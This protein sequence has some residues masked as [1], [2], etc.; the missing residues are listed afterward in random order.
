MTIISE[1]AM[2]VSS[3]TRASLGMKRIVLLSATFM[4]PIFGKGE[5]FN[6]WAHWRGHG[7]NS[8]SMTAQPPIEWSRSKN[9]KWKAEIPGRGSGSPVIWGNQV[10]VVSAVSE[11]D[12]AALSSG[13]GGS[14]NGKKGG[15]PKKFSFQLFCFDRETG[16]SIWSRTA[17]EAAPHEG[18]H[19]TNGYASASPCSDG[20]RV[21]AHFGSRGLF[22]YNMDGALLWSRTDLGKMTVRAGFGEGSSPT[23][24]GDKILVPW[25]HEGPSALYALD[26]RTGETIWKADRD[27]PTCWATPLVVPLGDSFQVIMNGQTKAR[28]YDLET[29]KELWSCGG[30]TERPVASAVFSQGITVIGSG[31]R[32][33][34]VGGF[35]LNGSGDIE[36]S[37]SVVWTTPDD[38][39]DIASPMISDGRLYFHKGKTGILTCLEAATGKLLFG[40]ERIP[41]VYS[42]YASPVAAG[43]HVYI[44]DRSGTITVVKDAGILE[45]VATN[46]LGEGVDATPA[47]VGSELFVRGERH[48]FCLSE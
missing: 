21:Y 43:G 10:F 2:K 27:E 22:C 14:Q 23:L 32:G 36:D 45:I 37:D 29:G 18:T 20:E 34:F 39:P 26:K 48:L 7:G 35:R 12:T 9:V 15:Y 3:L 6:N 11:R 8:V 41:G 24:A 25:D 40:P 16:K 5:E 38:A 46:T 4:L 19:Q 13:S 44:T 42:T 47:P 28:A 30:Q 17:V 1:I 31:F 33:S